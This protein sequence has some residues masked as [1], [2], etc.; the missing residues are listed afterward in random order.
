MRGRRIDLRG[1]GRR[2]SGA[3]N[4]NP[5]TNIV[6][7]RADTHIVDARADTD[8][9]SDS[10]AVHAHTDAH[11]DIANG[12]ANGQCCRSEGAGRTGEHQ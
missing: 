4:P 8:G 9:N 7:A 12:L 11:T 1:D 10:D 5:D 3:A 6:D 2:S